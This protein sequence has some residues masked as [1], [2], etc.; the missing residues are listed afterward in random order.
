[1]EGVP[2]G[3]LSISQKILRALEEGST[4][5]LKGGGLEEC[6]I[7][8]GVSRAYYA[9][10]LS[11]RRR[12]GLEGYSKSDVHKRVVERL[13]PVTGSK[14]RELR[15]YRNDADY[16]LRGKVGMEELKWVCYVAER[17]IREWSTP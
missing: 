16:N 7:R 8:T 3:F 2:E 10:F 5:D 6:W 1:M 11:A 9:A 4:L 15:Q 14:L 12:V 17:L 13:D